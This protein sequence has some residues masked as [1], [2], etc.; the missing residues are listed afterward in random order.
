[1]KVA[2]DGIDALEMLRGENGRAKILGPLVILL[3]LNMPGMDG[4]AFWP[5]YAP[6]RHYAARWCS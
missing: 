3:D 5:N 1:M 4:I 6:I 2:G